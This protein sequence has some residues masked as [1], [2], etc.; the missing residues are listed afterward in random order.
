[1]CRYYAHNHRCGHTRM[2]FAAYCAPAALIQRACA[3]GE[4]WQ[5]L[6]METACSRCFADGTDYAG[7]SYVGGGKRDPVS[8]RLP[9]VDARQQ[10]RQHREQ[11]KK[12]KAPT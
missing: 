2:V 6:R 5:T 7:D 11:Q 12:K 8:T 4:I 10:Q 3:S 1:M 9:I